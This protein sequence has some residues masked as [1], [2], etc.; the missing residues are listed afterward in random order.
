V[1][2]IDG[3]KDFNLCGIGKVVDG[4]GAIAFLTVGGAIALLDCFM[5]SIDLVVAVFA[6]FLDG[7]DDAIGILTRF[8]RD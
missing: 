8:S 3:F 2:L 6:G 5:C 7:T 4:G 1:A